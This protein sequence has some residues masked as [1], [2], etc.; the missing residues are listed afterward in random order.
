MSLRGWK[1]WAI[2]GAILG[3]GVVAAFALG[4]ALDGDD[5]VCSKFSA[6]NCAGADSPVAHRP[7]E[8]VPAAAPTEIDIDVSSEHEKGLLVAAR[9]G[10]LACHRFGDQGNDVGPDLTE[11]GSRLSP[12]QI[13]RALVDPGG[14]MPRFDD[15]PRETPL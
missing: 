11:V 7:E 9:A 5:E 13:R 10:C 4:S 3:A 15:E 1:A 2:A 8:G 14:I 12:A 6:Q